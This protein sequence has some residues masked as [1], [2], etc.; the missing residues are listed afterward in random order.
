MN[1]T[2]LSCPSPTTLPVPVF[3]AAAD[4][5]ETSSQLTVLCDLPGVAPEDLIIEIKDQV[6]TVSG[7]PGIQALPEG[8]AH[9]EYRSGTWKRSF[10]LHCEVDEPKILA[11]S[12]NGVLQ[13]TL[14][15]VVPSGP[16]RIPVTVSRETR[17]IP[18]PS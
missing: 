13:V 9:L 14:P 1:S 16:R 8:E 10:Q 6:L 17:E 11:A 5:H 18:S 4:I 2:P 7:T 15:K 3:R 12:R